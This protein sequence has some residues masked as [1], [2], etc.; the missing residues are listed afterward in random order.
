MDQGLL[1]RRYA[2]ALYKFAVEKNY[3]NQAFALMEK[4]IAAFDQNKD[5]ERV[6][7]NPFVDDDKKTSL[8]ITSC[9][10]TDDE[11]ITDFFKL[12]KKNKRIDIV[13]LTA[14]AYTDL[15]RQANNIYRVDV[16]TASPL[17]DSDM[18]RLTAMIEKHL[19]G[20]SAQYTYTVDPELIGGFTV[21]I[22]SQR[23]DASIK[24]ELKQLRLNLLK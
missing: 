4:L 13:R 16:T 10:A 24:N 21:T 3:D 22:D 17:S 11:P 23:L 14:L 6:M 8:L 20:A 1:P 19:A 12:L 5:L 7:S 18:K 15:Y 2:K 9:G